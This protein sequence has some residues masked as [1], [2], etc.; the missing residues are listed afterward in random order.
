M[1][2]AQDV[3]ARRKVMSKWD[4]WYH[5]QNDA[6]RAWLDNQSKLDQPLTYMSIGI[7]F[8]FGFIVGALVLL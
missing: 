5:N 6:T 1:T 7:G 2:S 4:I 8:F 3:T